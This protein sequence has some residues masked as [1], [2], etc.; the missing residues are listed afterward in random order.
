[1]LAERSHYETLNI[2]RDAPDFLIRAAYKSLSQKYHPDVNPEN[3]DAN[4]TMAAIN[5]AYQTLSDV[6]KRK[7]YDQWLEKQIVRNTA[8]FGSSRSTDNSFKVVK[9]PR[10]RKRA[11]VRSLLGSLLN[12]SFLAII[13]LFVL[14]DPQVIELRGYVMDFIKTSMRSTS[15]H[16]D[17]DEVQLRA[18][19]STGLLKGY[20]QQTLDGPNVILVSNAKNNYDAE[21]RLV[22]L[23]GDKAKILRFFYVKSG[24]TIEIEGLQNSYYEVR[25]KQRGSDRYFYKS[26]DLH[27]SQNILKESA[28]DA[29]QFVDLGLANKLSEA[30]YFLPD[31]DAQILEEQPVLKRLLNQLSDPRARFAPNGQPWPQRSGLVSGYRQIKTNGEHPIIVQNNDSVNAL[32]VMLEMGSQDRMIA[33]RTLYLKPSSELMIT[34]LEAGSYQLKLQFV[35]SD[36]AFVTSGFSVGSTRGSSTAR[37][38]PEIIQLNSLQWTPIPALY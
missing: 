24:E 4:A 10:Q 15:A 5:Y 26:I 28:L 12:F 34:E 17:Q 32:F 23:Q 33:L 7:S 38:K 16:N 36:E 31:A 21:A 19:G 18:E 13:S 3:P 2:T 35:T 37:L 1:M 22:S 14:S 11:T 8:Q 29:A 30:E 20:R 6:Q 27:S 9:E 25:F